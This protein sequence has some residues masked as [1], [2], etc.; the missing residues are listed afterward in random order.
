MIKLTSGESWRLRYF[1]SKT[2]W[3]M[4]TETEAFL[5]W[6]SFDGVIGCGW[7]WFFCRNQ[8]IYFSIN[9]PKK[10]K[11]LQKRQYC[12]SFG[13]H[14]ATNFLTQKILKPWFFGCLIIHIQL[15][16]FLT[17]PFCIHLDSLLPWIPQ[18]RLSLRYNPWPQ[19]V[20]F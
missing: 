3:R 12:H 10:E 8:V 15:S 7:Y 4:V 11:N 5:M 9:F 6:S 19:T 14:F 1:E 2:F 20:K 17:K 13:L 16:F 18:V